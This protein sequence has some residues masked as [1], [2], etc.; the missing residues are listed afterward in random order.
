[1]YALFFSVHLFYHGVDDRNEYFCVIFHDLE[2]GLG[3]VFDDAFDDAD[4]AVLFVNDPKTDNF[5]EV[6]LVACELG[7]KVEGKV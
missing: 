3:G 1:M 4:V 5:V 6:E 2:E 7:Q